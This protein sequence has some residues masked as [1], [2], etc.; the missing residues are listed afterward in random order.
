MRSRR[1]GRNAD[2]CTDPQ[3]H[4][5]IGHWLPCS[6]DDPAADFARHRL[7]FVVQESR[8]E[9]VAPHTRHDA[10]RLYNLLDA[11]SHR[12]QDRVTC[13]VAA[14]V[15]DDLESIKINM[16]NGHWAAFAVEPV[17]CFGEPAAVQ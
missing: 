15:I 2:A 8:D 7:R 11:E 3:L 6:G 10:V 13:S 17:H 1:D 12:L 5:L 9:L 14:G 16:K 4:P